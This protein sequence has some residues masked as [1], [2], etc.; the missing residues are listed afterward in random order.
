ML[1]KFNPYLLLIGNE[2]EL[3]AV[4][5]AAINGNEAIMRYLYPLTPK[6]SSN[7]WGTRSVASLLTSA[8]R[9]DAFGKIYTRTGF[10]LLS[11]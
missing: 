9:L 2:H 8:A 5:I 1:V 6:N 4:T 3:L 10:N 11:S 7:K